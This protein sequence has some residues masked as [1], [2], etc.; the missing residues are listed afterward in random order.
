[1]TAIKDVL[2]L[3]VALRF[4]AIRPIRAFSVLN[5]PPPK[6]EGHVPLTKIERGSL[7][8]GSAVMS[9]LN[10]RRGG[11]II[12]AHMIVH[13]VAKSDDR[14]HCDSGRDNRNTVLYLSSSRCHAIFTHW[15]SH[16]EKET[17]H[18]IADNVF[19]PPSHPSDQQ[20]WSYLRF[21]ARS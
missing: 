16:L 13:D 14:P 10:P 4:A 17:T 12:D 8:L 15:P 19:D 2:R 11:D 9:L 21:M 6:Y 18:N 1:M 20:R 3:H 7:A 5:R